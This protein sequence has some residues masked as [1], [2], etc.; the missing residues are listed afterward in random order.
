MKT[1]AI[2]LAS[3]TLFAIGCATN[4]NKQ[5]PT[6]P[7]TA[8]ESIVR[9]TEQQMKNAQITVGQPERKEMTSTL[10]VTGVI[11]VPPSNR[12]SVS[13]PLG[14]FIK[15]MDLFPGSRVRRG[16][17]LLVMEDPQYI[18]LQQDYLTAVSRLDFLEADYKRQRDLNVD[19]SISDKT[20]QLV[21]ADYTSQKILVRALGE[22][23]RLISIDPA[24]LNEDNISRSVTIS[25][26]IDGFVSEIYVNIGKYVNPADVL[27]D[28]LDERELQANL[29]VFEK[30]IAHISLGQKLTVSTTS[31]PEKEYVATVFAINKRLDAERSTQVLC[32]FQQ[33]NGTLMP[34]MFINGEIQL[35]HEEVT[36]VPEDAVVSWENES[37]VF[38]NRQ[39]DTFEMIHVQTGMS[40]DGF[41]EVLNLKSNTSL[42]LSNAYSLLMKIKG[43]S[44]E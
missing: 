43:V 12:F 2:I 11:D 40:G 8:S 3:V 28:L 9:L 29:T 42:V 36:A 34:G 14:G 39:S 31:D 37:Y 1:P 15:K 38:V 23:L 4:E 10:R 27:I 25:S 44:E 20:Y 24:T 21:R 33:Y 16:Q 26:P 7:P 41:I 19:K 17:V 30:D 18:Q 5:G 35:A 6:S 22:K 32:K 13:N